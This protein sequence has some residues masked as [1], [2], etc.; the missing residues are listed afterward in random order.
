MRRSG[1]ISIEFTGPPDVVRKFQSARKST[2]ASPTSISINRPE[3][4]KKETR[5]LVR[6]IVDTERIMT[7]CRTVDETGQHIDKCKMRVGLFHE[8]PSGFVC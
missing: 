2:P 6:T 1:K 5:T 4:R 3:E 7:V 8:F